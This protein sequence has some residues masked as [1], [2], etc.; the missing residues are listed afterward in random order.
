MCTDYLYSMFKMQILAPLFDQP[1]PGQRIHVYSEYQEILMWVIQE[2]QNERK[3]F[4]LAILSPDSFL[5][6]SILYF[7]H[8][9]T[10][11]PQNYSV[12]I[13]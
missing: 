6:P 4:R 13:N 7:H 3:Y 8:T 10:Q 11:P 5:L 1:W 12:S 9:Y 2:S